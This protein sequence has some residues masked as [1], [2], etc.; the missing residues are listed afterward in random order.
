MSRELPRIGYWI[1]NFEP[2]WEAASKEVQLLRDTFGATYASRM[3]TLDLWGR[4]WKLT[5]DDKHLPL[6][7]SLVGLPW[8]IKAARRNEVNHIFASPGERFLMPWLAGLGRTVLTISKQNPTLAG[9]ERNV[10]A[11]KELRYIVV[12]SERYRDLLLQVGV[13]AERVRLIYPGVRREPYRP[14]AGPFTILFATSP[15]KDGLVTRG[16][17]LMMRVAE[18]LPHIRFRL[19]WR[20]NPGQV[21]KLLERLDLENVELV[22]GFVEDM[23]SEYD[24]AHAVILP[25]LEYNSLKPCPHSGLHALAHGKPLLVSGRVSI[26]DVIGRERCGVIFE[27]TID[28]L[29][30]AIDNLCED[31]D[32]YQSRAHPCRDALFTTTGFIDR[33]ADLY[34]SLLRG[35]HGSP[36]RRRARKLA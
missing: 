22:T 8:I 18:R 28:G 25:A 15:R 2:K 13:S 27:P 7:Y 20:S 17:Y 31:Y 35:G 3:I 34:G 1:F 19:V 29:C 9:L 33:Y 24:A 4:R 21:M 26:A 32:A 10:E 12:E 14:A 30:R 5:G 23:K 11:L 16:I 6:P 36:E